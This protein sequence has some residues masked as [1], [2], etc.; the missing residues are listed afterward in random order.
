M[1]RKVFCNM[2]KLTS[3]SRRES[4]GNHFTTVRKFAII[5]KFGDFLLRIFQRIINGL[6]TSKSVKVA[7][8]FSNQ[9]FG[10]CKLDER[11]F[12]WF[13]ILVQTQENIIAPTLLQ[14]FVTIYILSTS[15]LDNGVKVTS[16]V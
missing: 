2:I 1:R 13:D 9:L 14:I 12:L 3:S 5:I 8:Y 10:V 11:L 7:S 6:T 16:L 4:S 15:Y